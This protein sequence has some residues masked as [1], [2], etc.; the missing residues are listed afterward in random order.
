MASGKCQRY[1]LNWL[2]VSCETYMGI[3][4]A[5]NKIP[6]SKSVVGHLPPF[7]PIFFSFSLGQS[8]NFNEE[9]LVFLLYA[10]L[11][12]NVWSGVWVRVISLF[13][14][15][16]SCSQRKGRK[17]NCSNAPSNRISTSESAIVLSHSS[18]IVKVLS[19][20]NWANIMNKVDGVWVGSGLGDWF[21]YII[22]VGHAVH[23]GSHNR[24]GE[25]RYK[26]KWLSQIITLFWN[27]A[28]G[29]RHGY[30]RSFDNPNPWLDFQFM[31]AKHNKTLWIK[32]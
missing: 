2:L 1:T 5:C 23:S 17:E 15:I 16:H 6:V 29:T 14:F 28:D 24:I 13:W 10:T 7:H 18:V 9:W 3:Y 27:G 22:I 32:A 26:K 21:W 30:V 8:L 20:N 12:T 25:C 11:K 31:N 19:S 4:F